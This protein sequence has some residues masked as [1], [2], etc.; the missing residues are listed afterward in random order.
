M[1][2]KAL[3]LSGAILVVLLFG[4][5]FF[6]GAQY[7]N[8]SGRVY[9]AQSSIH[10]TANVAAISTATLCAA[11]NCPAGEYEVH[12][13]FTQGGTACTV[14]TA[15]S[16]TFLLTW[17][18]TNGVAHSAVALPM[19]NSVSNIATSGS[20][21]F[22]TANGSAYASGNFHISTNGT[23]IQYATGYVGCTTGTGTYQL[24]ASVVR[25]Q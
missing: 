19:F 16:V 3:F 22:T 21:T 13:N 14:I 8:S 15:G 9:T 2:T 6:T 4:T 10:S 17:T 23:I 7:N 11:A 20:F 12:F 1:K 5:R 25:L 24:D 18:D